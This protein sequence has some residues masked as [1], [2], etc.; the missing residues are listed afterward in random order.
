M[1][2]AVIAPVLDPN[3]IPGIPQE[4]DIIAFN[5]EYADKNVLEKLLDW[6]YDWVVVEQQYSDEILRAKD[7]PSYVLYLVSCGSI[8]A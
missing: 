1:V 6:A 2:P 7:L 4:M 3:N 8:D 5:I